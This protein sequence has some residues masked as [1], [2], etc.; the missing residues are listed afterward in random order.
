M[1]ASRHSR[2]GTNESQPNVDV[3]AYLGL[4]AIKLL[5]DAGIAVYRSRVIVLCGN[6]FCL[7]DWRWPG[8][9]RR[10]S[11]LSRILR[12]PKRSTRTRCWSPRTAQG[13]VIG[14]VDAKLVAR[15]VAGPSSLSSGATLIAKPFAARA[16]PWTPVPSAARTHGNPPFRV[17]TRSGGPPATRRTQS[18]GRPA[19]RPRPVR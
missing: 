18:G 1:P 8:Q 10:A 11:R 14:P 3:F 12:R 5:T 17:G 7:L 19:T 6:P 15:R 4:M 16:F 2:R 13:D 9:R